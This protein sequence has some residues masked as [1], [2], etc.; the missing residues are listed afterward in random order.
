MRANRV[1][2]NSGQSSVDRSGPIRNCYW[3]TQC[4]AA[5][6]ELHLAGGVCAR[7]RDRDVEGKIV[8]GEWLF[9]VGY[10]QR[11]VGRNLGA[12]STTSA[13]SAATSEGK[14]QHVE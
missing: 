3:Q 8:A 12:P 1:S 11:R 4:G 10:G 7:R 9:R 2:A 13:T 5:L 6:E 14:A